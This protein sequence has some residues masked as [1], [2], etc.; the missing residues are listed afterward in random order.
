MLIIPVFPKVSADFKIEVTLEKIRCVFRIKWNSATQYWMINRY[1]EPENNI[2]VAGLKIIP[3]YPFLSSY[4]HSFDGEILCM[5]YGKDFNR[6]ITYSNFGVEW[7][8]V[9]LTPEEFAL[10][11]DASGF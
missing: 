2:T 11:S 3:N 4:N 9:Y 1:E 10:W 7:A 5:P 6:E 8:L